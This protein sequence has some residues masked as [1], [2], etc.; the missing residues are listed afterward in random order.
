MA[1]AGAIKILEQ[2]ESDCPTNQVTFLCRWFEAFLLEGKSLVEISDGGVC[3]ET[4][5]DGEWPHVSQ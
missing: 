2:G 3:G 4:S 1:T 5:D